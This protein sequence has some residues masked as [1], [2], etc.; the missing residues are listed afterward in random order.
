MRRGVFLWLCLGLVF[1]FRVELCLAGAGDDL[2]EKQFVCPFPDMTT[3]VLPLTYAQIRED[4]V[5]VYAQAQDEAA[6][7]P[8][9]RVTRKGFMWVSLSDPQ[10]VMVNGQE[11]YR[12]NEREYIRADKLKLAKPSGFQGV[13]VPRDFDKQ[14]AWMIFHTRV[15]PAP[16][17]LPLEEEDPA[18][19]PARS[20][21]IVHEIREVEQRKWCRIGTGVWVPYR[22]LAMVIPRLRPE[23]VGESE[24]WIEVNLTEQTLSAYEG[25]RLIFATLISSGDERFPTIKGLFRIWAKV[26]IG[27]MSGGEDDSDRYFVEDV[28]WHMYF[29][30]SYGLH[31][32]YWHDFFG[33]P[34]SHGCVN[35]AP[36]DALWLFE[37]TSPKA[38]KGNWQ[39]ATRSDPG[40]WVWVHETPPV[41]TGE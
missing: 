3:D 1:A 35:L 40:T 4:A 26:R 11:W 9:V 2:T 38:G 32:S 17:V 37:W 25:D 5:S 20:L 31:T 22:R 24:R 18:V 30:Q 29:Y 41:V 12:V 8:P 7:V 34:N 15:S 39:E 19:L 36:K 16:G 27:K 33:L 28:P 6:G 10:P 23:E 21:V 13:M 14:F